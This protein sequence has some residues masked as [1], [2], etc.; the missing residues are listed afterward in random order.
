MAEAQPEPPPT[1]TSDKRIPE[2]LTN[3][4]FYVE[5]TL[6]GSLDPVDAYFMDCKGFKR[7][8]EI[9]EVTEV[10]AQSWGTAKSGHVV[11]SK[12]P[13]N[14]KTNNI[15]LRRGL[16]KSPTLWQWFDSVQAGNWGKQ[17]RN[18]SISIYDQAGIVQARFT[19]YRA[20]P[21]SYVLT[22]FNA[23]SNEIEIEEMELAVEAFVRD[24]NLSPSQGP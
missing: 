22:D 1:R 21:T 15:T 23:G 13:G 10:T 3:C 12:I 14:V 2:V 8:Q 16:T 6:D 5:L 19:F 20:W 11:R 24:K 18:G 17:R 9:V 4:R 7:T